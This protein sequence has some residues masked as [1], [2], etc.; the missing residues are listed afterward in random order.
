MG[1]RIDPDSCT[2]GPGMCNH[3]WLQAAQQWLHTELIQ[4][5]TDA[6]AQSEQIHG[7]S[8]ESAEPSEELTLSGDN[9]DR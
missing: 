6:A 3:H 9:I 7:E 2:A 4:V 5:L 8:T 1:S